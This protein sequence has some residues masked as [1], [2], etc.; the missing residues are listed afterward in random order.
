M[1]L[2]SGQISMGI[3]SCVGKFYVVVL[4]LKFA[5]SHL[6]FL[7]SRPF[8]FF[9]AMSFS[10]KQCGVYEQPLDL[11]YPQLRPWIETVL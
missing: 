5:N 9:R 3:S 4:T 7:Y 1:L 11:L 10:N 6:K 8:Y 2:T